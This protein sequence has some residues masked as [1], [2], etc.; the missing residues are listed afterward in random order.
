MGGWDGL[1]AGLLQHVAQ[2]VSS[3]PDA[4][5]LPEAKTRLRL[6]CK[7]WRSHLPL[8]EPSVALCVSTELFECCV[9]QFSA[10][11]M[12]APSL[13]SAAA[14]ARDDGLLRRSAS[15]PVMQATACPPTSGGG[16]P[17]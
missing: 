15:S 1:P 5:S 13:A 16:R 3:L 12:R 7:G 2:L 14:R 11:W 6:V 17:P 9:H 10:R 8:G 4:S